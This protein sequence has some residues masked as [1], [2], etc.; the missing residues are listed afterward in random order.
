MLRRGGGSGIRPFSRALRLLGCAAA[1]AAAAGCFRL[2]SDKADAFESPPE[3]EP[4][5]SL[6]PVEPLVYRDSVGNPDQPVYP[7]DS[8]RLVRLW[9]VQP[10]EW[11]DPGALAVSPVRVF[12][13]DAPARAVYSVW[14]TGRN[15]P[16]VD[17]YVGLH[18]PTSIAWTKGLV[19]VSDSSFKEVLLID[20]T[21][22][23][24]GA[25]DTSSNP[26]VVA[27]GAGRFGVHASGGATPDWT[28]RDEHDRRSFIHLPLASA[29]G[30]GAGCTRVSG[31]AFL[32]QSSCTRPFF[33][34]IGAGGRVLR[35]VWIDRPGAA[36]GSAPDSGIVRLTGGVAAKVEAAL[37]VRG[38]RYD[39][40][41]R[42]FALWTEVA[43]GAETRLDLFSYEGVY[44]ARVVIPAAWRDFA[45]D[46]GMLFALEAE[47]AG[48]ARL[49]AYT[50]LL[51]GD[52]PVV[53]PAL[54]D[55]TAIF[56]APAGD[57]S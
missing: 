21:G 27:A 24:A 22:Y 12:V 19:A 10:H 6:G 43:A 49:A 7:D 3:N 34:V 15:G 25:L 50:L 38:V 20:S 44:L 11:E 39:E 55:T 46:G 53:S 40:R 33:R 4:G 18:G 48:P 32:L 5:S 37:P 13:L 30:P 54:P 41:G 56:L 45:F 2:R 52:G 47:D 31:G 36:D 29:E 42:R 23:G 1:L 14:R 8:V 26:V 16:R 28:V 35:R 57:G 9:R 17:R 51:P